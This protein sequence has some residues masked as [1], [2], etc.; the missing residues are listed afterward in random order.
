MKI[1]YRSNQIIGTHQVN[2]RRILTI[3]TVTQDLNLG[4]R[5]NTTIPN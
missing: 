2:N 4:E 3:F 5:L 1:N